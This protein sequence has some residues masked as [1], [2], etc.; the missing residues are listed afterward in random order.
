MLV[1]TLD[2]SEL[3]SPSHSALESER[4]CGTSDPHWVLRFMGRFVLQ[5]VHHRHGIPDW[6]D[7][8]VVLDEATAVAATSL[9]RDWPVPMDAASDLH[10]LLGTDLVYTDNDTGSC[11]FN[12]H[13]DRVHLFG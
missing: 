2:V 11:R 13:L 7:A 8:V 9:C 5:L 4:L 10:E 6:V 3:E 1:A 12:R